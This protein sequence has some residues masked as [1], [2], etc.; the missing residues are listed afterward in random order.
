MSRSKTAIKYLIPLPVLA[1]A[2][3]AAYSPAP[4]HAGPVNSD[5]HATDA[6]EVTTVTDHLTAPKTS[7]ETAPQPDASFTYT[8]KPG[9]TLSSIA[10]Q[11]FGHARYW[12]AIWKTNEHAIHNPNLLLTGTKLDI[13][14]GP[15]KVT[16]KLTAQAYSAIPKP[17][18]VHTAVLTA[19]PAA[20]P[21]AGAVHEANPVTHDAAGVGAYVNP[22]GYSGFQACVIHAESGGNPT[23]QNPSSSASGLYQFLLTT[24]YA[25]GYGQAYP[26]GAATAPVSVQTEA[27]WKEVAQ[28]GTSAWSAYDGC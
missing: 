10:K 9:D 26:G 3:G 12:P 17:P 19:A 7:W 21:S 1:F 24:W 2:A 16:A 14:G 4:T 23:A 18:P 25:L 15:A 20:S 28:S 22:S 8:V 11:L 6:P 27:F 5:T 13:P